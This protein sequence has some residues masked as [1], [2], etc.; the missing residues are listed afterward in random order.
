ME[1]T[2]VEAS[3]LIEWFIAENVIHAVTDVCTRNCYFFAS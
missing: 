3:M 2:D 1:G